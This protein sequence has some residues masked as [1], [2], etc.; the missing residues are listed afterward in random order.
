MAKQ[1]YPESYPENWEELLAG[2]V[3]GDLEPEE[4]TAM[5][6]LIAEHPTI[7][8]EIDRLQETLAMLPLGLNESYPAGD[9]RDRIAAIAVSPAVVENRLIETST[10]KIERSPRQRNL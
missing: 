4:V 8:T 2:Y 10:A 6:Q 3:L 9:L 5:H 7:I 1:N